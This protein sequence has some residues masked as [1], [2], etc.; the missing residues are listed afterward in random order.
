MSE[1]IL[2][3]VNGDQAGDKMAVA[4]IAPV[5]PWRDILHD[6][7]VGNDPASAVFRAARVAHIVS[8]GWGTEAE[9]SASFE[10]RDAAFAAAARESGGLMLWFEA[11][12]YD[13][14]QILDVLERARRSGVAAGRLSAHVIGEWPGIDRFIGLGQLTPAD[15]AALRARAPER[16]DGEMLAFAAAAWRAFA[17]AEPTGLVAVAR[18]SA[19]GA[20]RFVPAALGR[21]MREYPWR[22]DGLTLTQRRALDAARAGVSDRA[23]LFRAVQDA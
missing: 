13:Q 21:W 18:Q 8:R 15:F 17:A 19:T 12:L 4:G 6:G 3:I 14:L 16:F 20:L 2:H 9:I 7:P 10:A 11:D 1:P 22:S 5:L 23:G